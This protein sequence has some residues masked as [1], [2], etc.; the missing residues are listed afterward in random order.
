MPFITP[1]QPTVLQRML[2]NL[3]NA[4]AAIDVSDDG[5]PYARAA[6]VSAEI[7]GL[8]QHQQWIL[9]Q[10]FPDTADDEYMLAY[11]SRRGITPRLAVAAT[12]TITYSG[13]VGAAVPANTEART[14]GGVAYINTASGTIGAGGTVTLAAQAVLAGAAGN[15]AGGT[16][17]TL[18]AAPSG[19][20]SNAS[21]ASMTS[22]A[23][24]ESMQSVLDRLLFVLR[25]PPMSGAAHDYVIWAKAVSGVLGAYVSPL[26]RGGSTVDVVI[27]ASGG[28]PSAPLINAVQAYINTLKPVQADVLV[29]GPTAVTVPVTATLT[30]SGTTLAA[31]SANI[32]ADLAAYFATL[33]PGDMVVRSKLSAIFANTPGVVD[34]NLTAP[35]GN[36]QPLL[37]AT[38]TELGVLGAVTLS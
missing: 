20:Q 5:E 25:N 11:A 34:F 19:V 17:L 22:G 14:A 35:A 1:D 7:E 36:V 15:A 13:T 16:A 9:R 4:N 3:S 2:Q 38:H 24:V 21:I 31:I 18:T 33:K 30:L 32:N 12:G 28:L 8:Y 26:R 29:L 6:A 37:D 23:D 10:L 27:T